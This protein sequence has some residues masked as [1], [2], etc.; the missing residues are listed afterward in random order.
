MM[1]AILRSD[2]E[3]PARRVGAAAPRGGVVA[4]WPWAVLAWAA[5]LV[6]IVVSF[7]PAVPVIWGD[8][9]SFVEFALRTLEAVKP[10]VARA[11]DP[12]YP[13]FLSVTFAF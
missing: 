3:A 13:A 8:T 4:R 6:A 12:L 10:T 5:L 11:R 9:P 1:S 7:R 2:R